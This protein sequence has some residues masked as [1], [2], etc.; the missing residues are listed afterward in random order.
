M[1]GMKIGKSVSWGSSSLDSFSPMTLFIFVQRDCSFCIF[2]AWAIIYLIVSCCFDCKRTWLF[3]RSVDIHFH[4]WSSLANESFGLSAKIELQSWSICLFMVNRSSHDPET[5]SFFLTNKFASH[6][7]FSWNHIYVIE[8]MAR[9][10]N[11]MDL[12]KTVDHFWKKPEW[13][14]IHGHHLL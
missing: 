2:T 11:W 4:W 7:S 14:G 1:N 10:L 5:I 3:L 8:M 13:K 6:F 12:F 9:I